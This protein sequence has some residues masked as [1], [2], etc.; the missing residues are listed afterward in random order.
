MQTPT[1]FVVNLT[2]DRENSQQRAEY[3]RIAMNRYDCSGVEEYALVES[4]VDELLGERSY[5]GGDLPEEVIEEV[6]A[7]TFEQQNMLKFYF[8]N[9]SAH[10]NALDFKDYLSEL[11]KS[12]QIELEKVEESDWNSEWKKHYAPIHIDTELVVYPAWYKS[13]EISDTYP[14]Y[15]NPGMGF[16]TGTHETTFLCLTE[17]K[18][19]SSEGQ[20]Y[21]KVLDFGCGSGILGIAALLLDPVAEV[22]FYDIDQKALDNTVE[23]LKINQLELSEHRLLLEEDKAKLADKYEL[24][25]ANIL[26][27][28]LIQEK[29]FLTSRLTSTGVLILSG[30]LSN[31]AQAVIDEYELS[32]ELKLINILNKGDWVCLQF[33]KIL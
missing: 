33:R 7:A 22:D 2:L 25:F 19:I 4:E 27:H 6:D 23:N 9:E 32:G 3:I 5:S 15:I 17:F 11:K 30:I 14:L 31:Q 28:I 21:P 13:N 12:F 20:V 8:T 16:G 1:S 24:I 29:E 26:A 10:N 18:K